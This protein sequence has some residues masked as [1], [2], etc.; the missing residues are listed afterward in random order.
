[1]R[2]LFK[3][4][5]SEKKRILEMHEKAT[6]KNYLNE[7]PSQQPTLKQ[8]QATV[9]IDDKQY[10]LPGIVDKK[11]LEN[12]TGDNTFTPEELTQLNTI[13]GTTLQMES[14]GGMGSGMGKKALS[15]VRNSL[16]YLAQRVSSKENLCRA[17]YT[18]DQFSEI[19][20]MKEVSDFI[21]DVSKGKTLADAVN[22]KI[23]TSQ[24]CK[25]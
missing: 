9:T 16:N 12:F 23:K 3:I 15:G 7:Q 11:S 2:Q 25:S 6:S 8:P 14:P 4:D 20:E 17:K 22:Y 19:P 24:Y 10:K 13:L 21:S 18:L 5:E 1:M